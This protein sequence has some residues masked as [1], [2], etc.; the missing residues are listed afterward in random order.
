MSIK[1]VQRFTVTLGTFNSGGNVYYSLGSAPT[2]G[3]ITSTSNLASISS[4]ASASRYIFVNP[5]VNFNPNK[6]F[7]TISYSGHSAPTNE[8]ITARIYSNSGYPSSSTTSW[9]QIQLSQRGN[10]LVS[11]YGGGLPQNPSVSIEVVEFE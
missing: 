5:G 7:L 10:W 2:N 9:N 1:R 8:M 11:S 3:S 4:P 6:T